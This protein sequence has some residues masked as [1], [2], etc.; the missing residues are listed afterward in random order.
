MDPY[1]VISDREK[2][3]KRDYGNPIIFPKFS[4][5]DPTYTYSVSPKQTV[6]G[7]VDIMSH[8]FEQY[9]SVSQATEVQDS[10]AE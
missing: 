8:I 2:Q 3:E 4:I 7:I 9:F 1:M 6:A 5:L 10:I